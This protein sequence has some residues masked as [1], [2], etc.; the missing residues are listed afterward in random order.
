MIEDE[1]LGRY[2]II[3]AEERYVDADRW[4]TDWGPATS[5]DEGRTFLR[6]YYPPG[7]ELAALRKR[8]RPFRA[9]GRQPGDAGMALGHPMI[10]LDAT[11]VNPLGLHAIG[12]IVPP[13]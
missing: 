8:T 12:S 10:Q 4:L 5:W 13:R 7:P 6:S 2:R 3:Q 1:S 11:I 9:R